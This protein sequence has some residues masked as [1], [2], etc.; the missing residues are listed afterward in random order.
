MLADLLGLVDCTT[1]SSHDMY[2]QAM[3]L[4]RF[5]LGKSASPWSTA[6]ILV[7]FVIQFQV[8]KILPIDFCMIG[9][10][11]LELPLVA[12]VLTFRDVV[13][14]SQGSRL[15]AISSGRPCYVFIIWYKQCHLP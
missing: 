13:G 7:E 4:G 3:C 9:S 1:K 6:M 10:L 11:F 5:W 14:H 2:V 12:E 8:R 15:F